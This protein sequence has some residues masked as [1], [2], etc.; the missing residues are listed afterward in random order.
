MISPSKLLEQLC[1]L[2]NSKF[3]IKKKTHVKK[4]N[5][6]LFHTFECWLHLKDRGKS[7]SN[8]HERTSDSDINKASRTT[9]L[10]LLRTVFGLDQS[11]TYF[12]LIEFYIDLYDLQFSKE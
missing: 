9:A 1:K 5:G 12:S 8:F 4:V 10:N 7:T 6:Q 2:E 11:V 3:E